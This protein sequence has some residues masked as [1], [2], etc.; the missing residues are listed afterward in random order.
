MKPD[1]RDLEQQA[2][3]CE[4]ALQEQDRC[5]E[6]GFTRRRML[7]GLG[8]VGV[9]A[10]AEQLVTTRV[11]FAAG[12]GTDTVIVVFLRGGADGLRLLVPAGSELGGDYLRTVR[13][14]LMPAAADQ[15]AL[16]GQA[17]WAVHTSFSPLMPLWASGELAFVPAVAATGLSRSHFQAQQHLERGGSSSA[18]GWLD[19]VLRQLGAGTTFRAMGMGNAQP[20]SLVGDELKL[21]VNSLSTFE[22]SVSGA[23]RTAAMTALAALYRDERGPLGTDVPATLAALD[24]VAAVRA[25]GGPQN[26]AVYPE[27]SFGKAMSQLAL[28]LRA[29]VGLEVATVDVGGW[30]THTQEVADLDRLSTGT[31][32]ALS[33]FLA[34]L[35]P[36]RRSRVTVVVM[37]EF[38][39]RVAMNGTQGTD[40]GHGSLMWLLGGGLT[41]SA[42]AGGWTPLSAG[43]LDEGDV[44][45]RNH[46]YD[47]LG[48]VVQRRLG[49]GSVGTVFPGHTYRP[50]GLMRA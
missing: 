22:F 38:G 34:D 3:R 1:L 30:D 47:V 8:M 42:V 45:L 9:A 12:P 7:A 48:E 16:P 46:A 4:A 20:A 13:G 17:G 11:S 36:Q 29:E 43:V 15:L 33:A 27:G 14:P 37:T 10:L 39:R 6:K 50:L 49:V 32:Q 26:G 41:R 5:W 31:A 28:L 23:T 35:G 25:S 18:S 40:H 21:A 2:H 44:P 24:T 19:R